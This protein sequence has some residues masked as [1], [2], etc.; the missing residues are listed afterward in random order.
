[1][2]TQIGVI[3]FYFFI[4]EKTTQ[5]KRLFDLIKFL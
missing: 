3:Y 5:Y 4:L 1:M 2:Q